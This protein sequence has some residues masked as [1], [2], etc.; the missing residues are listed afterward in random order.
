M[1]AEKSIGVSLTIGDTVVAGLTSIGAFGVESSEIDVTSLDSTGGYKEFLMSL[2]DSG[3]VAIKGFVKED[4][5]MDTLFGIADAQS[6]EDCEVEFPSG[7]I[8]TFSAFLKKFMEGESAV[9]GARGFEGS[10]R[11]SGQIETTPEVSA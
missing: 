9:E 4:A 11:I 3:E 5:Q 7:R 8:Y 2:K 6:L 1:A 10:L